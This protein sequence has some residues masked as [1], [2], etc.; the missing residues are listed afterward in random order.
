MYG[1]D[2][3]CPTDVVLTPI[4]EMQPTITITIPSGGDGM[5]LDAQLER[6]QAIAQVSSIITEE[7]RRGGLCRNA[8]NGHIMATP[9]CQAFPAIA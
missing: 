8:E 4:S 1:V 9:L 6:D 2:I 3:T 7:F 5:D